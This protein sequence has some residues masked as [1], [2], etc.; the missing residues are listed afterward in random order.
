MVLDV[1]TSQADVVVVSPFANNPEFIKHY[2]G[3]HIQHVMGPTGK[4]I[5]RIARKMVVVSSIL[6]MQGY[7]FRCRH[8]IPY[9]WAN[10]HNQFGENGNDRRLGLPYRIILDFLSWIGYWH[11]AWKLFD[12]LHGRWSYR[13]PE[14]KELTEHYR[15]VILIQASSWGFQDAAM[16]YLGRKLKWR[17][18]MLPYTSDQLFCN[19][20]LYSNF[21]VVC[22]QGEA[23][24]RFAK[25]F[26]EIPDTRIA[27]LG[28]LNFISM[29]EVLGY[30]SSVVPQKEET[31]KA[32]RIL[33]AGGIATYFPTES[34]FQCLEYLLTA[35]DSGNLTNV[36]ITYRPIGHNPDI[37]AIIQ[38]RF[39]NRKHLT[40]EFASP[41]VYG[42]DTYIDCKWEQIIADHIEKI[43]GFD[44]MVMAGGTTLALDVAVFGTASISYFGDSSGVLKKRQISLQ[45]NDGSSIVFESI[46]AVTE[47]PKLL[48][49]IKD[50]L[51][52]R[53]S[54]KDIV[55]KTLLEWDNQDPGI[56]ERLER[57]VF[58]M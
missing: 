37:R 10:R 5:S 57:A 44:L 45:L 31:A 41:A 34:E 25:I 26:H 3:P 27:K 53:K 24:Q 8:K 55:E 14:L 39:A 58:S 16:A 30:K 50:L 23:E 12:L 56:M 21:D 42:L 18:V 46:P 49:L 17:T 22:V 11:R 13:F 32:S 4:S 1:L 20:Y 54:R 51:N 43:G 35:I 15:R 2:E 33:F 48:R 52:D 40:I 28:S 29:R 9:Y 6:R 36:S 47:I 19:G 38:Q 7:W